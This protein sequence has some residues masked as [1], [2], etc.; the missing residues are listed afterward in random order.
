MPG[1]KLDIPALH[2]TYLFKILQYTLLEEI[3]KNI[4]NKN[5][6]QGGKLSQL[7]FYTCFDIIQLYKG[8]YIRYYRKRLLAR[9]YESEIN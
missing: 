1:T 5:T 3:L 9:S 6:L 7:F 2:K 4:S 8:Y